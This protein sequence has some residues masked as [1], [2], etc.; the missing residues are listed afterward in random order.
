MNYDARLARAETA[1]ATIGTG[2]QCP[3]CG[4]PPACSRVL[5]DGQP[6]RACPAC[7]DTRH[8]LRV[9][10]VAPPSTGHAA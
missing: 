10:F 4:L 8:T 1:L 7:A 6:D 9:V 2:N 5:V 3:A